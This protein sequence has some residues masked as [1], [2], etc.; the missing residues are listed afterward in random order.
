MTTPTAQTAPD[1][2][3]LSAARDKAYSYLLGLQKPGGDWEG[4]MVWCTMILAQAVI[5]R[6]IVGKP[7]DEAE[8]RQIIRHF[9][10]TQAADGAW[11]MHPESPGYVFFTTLAY[12][13]LRLL[14]L[15]PDTPML[16]QARTWFRSQ[17]GGVEGIP[18]WGKFWL[19]IIGLYDYRGLNAIPPE[20][21]LLPKWLPF[22]PSRF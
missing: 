4:E 15:P 5:V 9:E 22:H 7:Y 1:A 2:A 8:Q 13:A 16:R 11:G 6:T 10:I 3:T 18:T 19:A 12:V 17:P 20:L 21:F 14:G